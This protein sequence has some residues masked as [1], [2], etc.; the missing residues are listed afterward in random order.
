MVTQMNKET[1]QWAEEQASLYQVF[2]NPRRVLILLALSEKELSVGE[3]TLLVGASMQNTSQHLR[4]MKDRGI[5][6]SRRDG[7]MIY[8]SIVNP[9]MLHNLGLVVCEKNQPKV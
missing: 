6:T 7:Q 1:R 5:L 9:I 4:I 2:T 3:I 8:Y